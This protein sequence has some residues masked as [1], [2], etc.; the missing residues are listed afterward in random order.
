MI[1][2]VA[3]DRE[4]ILLILSKIDPPHDSAHIFLQV[5]SNSL[6]LVLGECVISLVLSCHNKDLK[7]R[8]SV[9]AWLQLRVLFV[10]QRIVNPGGM[11]AGWPQKRGL[12]PF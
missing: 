9:I 10:K 12:N 4:H 11:R 2:V 5:C 3:G 6:D 1:G 8:T 7:W